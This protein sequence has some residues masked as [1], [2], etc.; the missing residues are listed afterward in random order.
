MKLVSLTIAISFLTACSS[1]PMQPNWISL[2][3]TDQFTDKTTCTVTTGSFYSGG[4]IYTLSNHYYPYIAKVDSEIFVG[5]Q[6]GG[7]IKM[8]VGIIQLRID[9]NTAWTI[10]TAE[11]P[12]LSTNVNVNYQNMLYP[13]NISD[14]Q[15]KVFDAT[16]KTAMDNVAKGMSPFTAT[17]GDKAHKILSE[18]LTGNKLIY[19][20]VGLNQAASTTGEITLDGSLKT[21]LGQCGIS[22]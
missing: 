6:S 19:R 15:K 4:S 14:E 1:N 9:T 8:P 20:T 7:K 10:T 18:M 12:L 11:T 5:I 13:E 17:T 16:Y 3:N 22:L 2:Q 21:A